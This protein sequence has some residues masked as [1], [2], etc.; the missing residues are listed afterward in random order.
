MGKIDN[1]FITRIVKTKNND[2][3][4][5]GI[6]PEMLSLDTRPVFVFIQKHAPKHKG[7][8]PT[9]ATIKQFFPSFKRKKAPESVSFY[10]ELLRKRHA[11]SK[12]RDLTAALAKTLGT[13]KP[14]VEAALSLV[15]EAS[16]G[17][18]LQTHTISRVYFGKSPA[19]RIRELNKLKSGLT[20]DFSLGHDVLNEDL[21]GAEKGNFF[22]IAV[23][24]L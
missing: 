20:A 18:S 23:Q 6:T 16:S 4:S 3:L 22:I 5:L 7:K 1:Q 13:E 21:I 19:E 14:D 8:P 2:W 9:F 11:E 10:G 12:L 24:E 17:I 15:S